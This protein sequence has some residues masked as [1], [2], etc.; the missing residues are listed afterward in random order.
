MQPHVQNTT[1]DASANFLCNATQAQSWYPLCHRLELSLTWRS[2]ST[3][4]IY[5]HVYQTTLHRRH[6]YLKF[7]SSAQLR[8]RQYLYYSECTVES[9]FHRLVPEQQRKPAQVDRKTDRTTKT[10]ATKRSE[11]RA[12]KVLAFA[13]MPRISHQHHAV[14]AIFHKPPVQS[15]RKIDKTKTR[16][17]QRMTL[18]DESQ[19][20][21][22]KII[23]GRRDRNGRLKQVG[24]GNGNENGKKV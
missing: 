16:W 14:P 21:R 3:T 24:H 13:P 11:K 6:P 9:E 7:H 15:W 17:K 1:T 20:K 10:R 19:G 2:S 12:E 22:D 8:I 5:I 18:I 4:K 23:S